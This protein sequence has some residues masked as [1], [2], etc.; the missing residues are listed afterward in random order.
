MWQEVTRKQI[1]GQV[2]AAPQ[3]GPRHLGSAEN[4]ENDG[5]H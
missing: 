1:R 3:E 5:Q 4:T 2:S